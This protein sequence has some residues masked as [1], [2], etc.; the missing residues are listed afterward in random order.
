MH[1]RIVLNTVY[2]HAV[3]G[4]SEEER[5]HFDTALHEPLGASGET[6]LRAALDRVGD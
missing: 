5:E 4:A 6:D 2:A 3:S 1:P